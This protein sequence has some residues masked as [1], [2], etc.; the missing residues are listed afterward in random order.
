MMN[1]QSSGDSITLVVKTTPELAEF[2][3]RSRSK[4]RSDEDSLLLPEVSSPSSQDIP[5]K[6]RYWLIH[7]N[8]YTLARLLEKTSTGSVK[9]AIG[10]AEMLVDVS[11]VDRANAIALDRAEDVTLLPYLNET[12]VLHVLRHRFGSSLLYTNVGPNNVICMAAEHQPTYYGRLITLFKGCRSSQMPPHIYATAQNVYRTM[13]MTGRDQCIVLTGVSG[14]GK[15]TQLQN[16][17][18]Y[19]CEVAGWLK[20][21]PYTKI[22]ASLGITEAFGNCAITS[23]ENGSRFAQL[24]SLHFDTSAALRSAKIQVF[25]LESSRIARHPENESNFHVFY[26][27]LE[28]APPEMRK[29][30][31]LDSITSCRFERDEDKKAAFQGWERLMAAFATLSITKEEIFTICSILAALLHLRHAEAT[32]GSAQ[33]AKFIRTNS[34]NVAAALL[35]LCLE[36]LSAAVFRG[37][38]PQLPIKN[39]INRFSMSNR[40]RNGQE[41][42]ESFIS[43]LYNALF[44]SIVS[45]INRGL[46]SSNIGISSTISVVDIPG[47][48]IS[49]QWLDANSEGRNLNDFIFNYLNDRI[50]ELFYGVTFTDSIDLYRKE[51]VEVDVDIP[52]TNPS[53]VARLADQKPQLLNCTDIEL[54]SAEK[55]GLL[56]ILEEESL[57]PGATDDSFYERIFMHLDDNRLIRRCSRPREFIVNH[58]VGNNP[59]AY[60]VNGWVKAA[61]PGHSDGTILSLLQISKN[62]AIS[63]LFS[64][65]DM[66]DTESAQLRRVTQAIKMGAARMQ[67][68][69]GFFANIFDQANYI[70]S[71]ARRSGG[72]HFVHCLRPLTTVS[73]SNARKEF[74]DVPFVRSQLKS[75]LLV[76]AARM[77]T[78]GN[79]LSCYTLLSLY[80]K[81]VIGFIITCGK[82]ER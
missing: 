49:S 58:G 65:F 76:D 61:Q 18:Q 26:F 38:V 6:D 60:T 68:P 53:L 55:R 20:S 72:I 24:Y 12:S 82:N 21:F 78:R 27:L 33:K 81:Q 43:C 47:N 30:L 9:I 36:D 37:N 69:A 32:Q 17:C 63:N 13:Q 34:A 56:C 15:S 3:D 5:E 29:E 74:L 8:G 77:Y 62:Q 79:Q 39:S 52:I 73:L 31:N 44:A 23:N 64:P 57:F 75:L 59:V 40:S 2:F 22:A 41:S 51:H 42:L 80:E 14:S 16:I 1:I 35:G 7:K 45:L 10:D 4:S 48:N 70:V 28:G 54:R 11:D 19:L 67:F 50:L 71:F 46:S 66:S 25:L